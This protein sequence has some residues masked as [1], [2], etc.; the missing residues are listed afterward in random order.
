MTDDES[1][2]KHDELIAAAGRKWA[3]V[4]ARQA[5]LPPRE[6]AEAAHRPGGPSVEELTRRI[7]LQRA[8]PTDT[9]SPPG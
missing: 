2:S 7:E 8:A 6:A 9:S 1:M 5:A 4:C 3:A